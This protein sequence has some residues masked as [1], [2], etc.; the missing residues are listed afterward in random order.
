M[1]TVA[2]ASAAAG[3]LVALLVIC[4]RARTPASLHAYRVISSSRPIRAIVVS[5]AR[6][7]MRRTRPS[8][9]PRS[10]KPAAARAEPAVVGGT[11]RRL[12]A[13][14]GDRLACRAAM[15][16]FAQTADQ[17]CDVAVGQR[18]AEPF[19]QLAFG[20]GDALGDCLALGG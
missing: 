10:P 1:A 13:A 7:Q 15:D 12:G 14:A 6:E 2:A 9:K 8:G 20:L 3:L 5:P 19:V 17:R 11:S 18:L 4:R 16:E